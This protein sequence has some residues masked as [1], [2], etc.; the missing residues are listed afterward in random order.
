MKTAA[1]FLKGEDCSFGLLFCESNMI[2][3]YGRL[4]WHIY[5]GDVYC[6]QPAGRVKFELMNAMIL[7][8]VRAP[9]G[10]IIDLCG[11]PW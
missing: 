3:F 4:G 5:G 6:E 9:E 2:D 11:R 8:I 1:E 10:Q 7:P